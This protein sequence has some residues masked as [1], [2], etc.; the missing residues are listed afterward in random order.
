IWWGDFPPEIEASFCRGMVGFP[1]TNVFGMKLLN[2][3]GGEAIFGSVVVLDGVFFMC[4]R[5]TFEQLGGFD[6]Q[7]FR[8]YHFYDIDI[9]LRAHLAGLRNYAA[10]ISLYHHSLG[11]YDEIWEGTRQV[12]VRKHSGRL[13]CQ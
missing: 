1:D 6:D 9:T 5:R 10:P 12:F 7:M 2:W 3:P 11:I 13:P 8:G 4:R